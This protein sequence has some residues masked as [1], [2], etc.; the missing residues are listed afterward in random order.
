SEQRPHHPCASGVFV[1]ASPRRFLERDITTASS[2]ILRRPHYRRCVVRVR[3]HTSH[4]S[5]SC[6]AF[7]T[8]R[9]IVPVDDFIQRLHRCCP[10]WLWKPP[11][12]SRRHPDRPLSA[13][14][15]R[16][17]AVLPHHPRRLR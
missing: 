7:G 2:H 15:P 1:G 5:C 9:H 13:R 4:S 16:E 8:R 12:P 14:S 3:Q 11:G 10:A 6:V 17:T